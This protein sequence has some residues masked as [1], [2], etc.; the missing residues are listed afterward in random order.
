MAVV[1]MRPSPFGGM[2]PRTLPMPAHACPCLA[3]L[4]AWV[5][6]RLP[7]RLPLCLTEFCERLEARGS[8]AHH[9]SFVIFC[10]SHSTP[11]PGLLQFLYPSLTLCQLDVFNLASNLLIIIL[12]HHVALSSF[13]ML[14]TRSSWELLPSFKLFHHN[15]ALLFR[16]RL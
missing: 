1:L 3:C 2:P 11:Q 6:L 9:L 4:L 7:L 8:A 14:Q 13:A 16:L 5:P 12:H 15:K 10:C